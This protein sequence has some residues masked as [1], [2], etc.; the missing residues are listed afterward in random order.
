M[1]RAQASLALRGLLVLL[2]LSGLVLVGLGVG[3]GIVG[4]AAAVLLPFGAAVIWGVF[5]VPHDP[6]E[7][8][9]PI[10]GPLRLVIEVGLFG[11]TAL[12]L[13]LAGHPVFAG[14]LVV[15]TVAQYRLA[16]ERL[17]LLLSGG[18]S[19]DDTRDPRA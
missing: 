13:W 16:T 15:L 17:Q 3:P 10:P 19:T 9:V 2:A 7:A 5:R 12:L 6:G 18:I 11:G 1:N 4:L 14:F 8:V